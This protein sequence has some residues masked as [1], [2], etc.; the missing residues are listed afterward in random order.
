M[1]MIF[2]EDI[3]DIE[4]KS[5]SLHRSFLNCTLGEADNNAN[6][7]GVRLYRNSE[8][9]NVEDSNVM[10][11]FMAPSG[12]NYL[13]S[14]TTYQGST[15]KSGNMAYVTLPEDCYAV[16]GQFSLAIKL[17]GGGVTGTMRIVDGVISRTGSTGAV[18]PTSSIPTSEEIIAAYEEAIALMNG[19]VRHD[20]AQELTN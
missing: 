8:P 5:G 3:M 7:F 18:A 12:T 4:L 11:L 16:E 6:R 13:I 15:G 9:V 19:A 14:E 20:V 17:I 1:A 2:H 10:G